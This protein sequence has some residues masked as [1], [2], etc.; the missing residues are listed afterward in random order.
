MCRDGVSFYF[1]C[2][3]VRTELEARGEDIATVLQLS[4]GADISVDTVIVATGRRPHVKGMGLEAA[5]VQYSEQDGI[6]VNDYLR[7]TNPNIF[8]VGDCCSQFQFTHVA[9]FMAR[10]AI[11]N[12]LFF[13]RSQAS[14]LLIPWCTYT[15]PEIAHVGLYPSDLVEKNIPYKKYIKY[16]HDNDRAVCESSVEGF[17]KVFWRHIVHM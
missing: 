3:V 13:G 10:I 17:V 6:R 8:A 15:E 1:D 5:G 16:F 12:A 2:N 14:S 11:R 7:T 9:D 4:T